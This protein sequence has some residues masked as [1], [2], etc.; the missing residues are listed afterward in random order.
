MENSL[1]I[2]LPQLWANVLSLWFSHSPM[3]KAL[4]A[5]TSLLLPAW[6]CSPVLQRKAQEGR[7]EFEKEWSAHGAPYERWHHLQ[8]R[9]HRA[10]PLTFLHKCHG[11]Y[12]TGVAPGQLLFIAPGVSLTCLRLL[13]GLRLAA[14]ES[15]GITSPFCIG[16]VLQLSYCLLQMQAATDLQV[17]CLSW[18]AQGTEHAG[19][20]QT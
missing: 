19:S 17:S 11:S 6:I 15:W 5:G 13:P 2:E 16:V 3:Y 12:A 4:P 9:S 10:C 1:C 7:W 14:Y 20:W 8:A 18:A